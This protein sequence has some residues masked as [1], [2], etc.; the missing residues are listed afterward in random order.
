MSMALLLLLYYFMF[1]ILAKNV[2]FNEEESNVSTP[3]KRTESILK[4]CSRVVAETVSNVSVSVVTFQRC[5]E[6]G[7][8]LVPT[9][10]SCIINKVRFDIWK[11]IEHNNHSCKYRASLLYVHF[12]LQFVVF[13]LH[14]YLMQQIRPNM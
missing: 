4:D 7:Y 8:D 1:C 13:I 11:K 14:N 3:L 10:V 6:Y 2:S 12:Y 5:V 9:P